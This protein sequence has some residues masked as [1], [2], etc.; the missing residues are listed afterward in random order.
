MTFPWT[1]P[2]TRA[3]DYTD[4]LV[5]LLIQQ[6][7]GNTLAADSQATAAFESVV[8]TVGRGFAACEVSADSPTVQAALTP[9][10][11]ELAGR[12]LIRGGELV[13]YIDTSGGVVN[14]L[15]AQSHNVYGGP[16]PSGWRYD[17]SLSGPSL[18]QSY[19]DIPAQSVVHLKYASHKTTPW[20]GQ[21]PIEVAS[22]SGKLSAET[23]KALGDEAGGPVGR[24]LGL[25][26]D[27]D[28]PG[29]A[30]FKRDLA[31]ARGGIA[32]V[33]N[34]DWGKIDGS[35]ASMKTERFGA[36]PSR[37][38]VD[39]A[40]QASSEIF[41]ACG[42]NPALFVSGDSASLR[43]AWRLALF[44]CLWPLGRKVAAELSLKLGMVELSWSE[45]RAS[46]L[47]GRARGFQ[48]L[49]GGGLS[50]QA[51]AMEAGLKHTEAAPQPRMAENNTP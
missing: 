26:T 47:Q 3:V 13:C 10:F 14:L 28:D 30:Q 22:L 34:G 25:P 39:L 2:E 19:Y 31:A 50:V 11:M 32:T 8:G 29:I 24:I 37:P 43:E 42:I 5:A 15:P 16:M 9:D 12:S 45:L 46:D 38:L 18:T 27:G 40:K 48:S 4:T 1:K 21:S 51:A 44:G 23:I 17:V 41:S 49:V 36:E 33:E 35:Y 20:R 7:T 6:A